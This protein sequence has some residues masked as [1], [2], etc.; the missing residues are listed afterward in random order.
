MEVKNTE[1]KDA[2][3]YEAEEVT[4]VFAMM[5]RTH[6]GRGLKKNGHTAEPETFKITNKQPK[7]AL[8]RD[9]LLVMDMVVDEDD[10]KKRVMKKTQRRT[11]QRRTKTRRT[12]QKR[13]KQRRTRQRRQQ[14]RLCRQ[15]GHTGRNTQRR[16]SVQLNL[17]HPSKEQPKKTVEGDSLLVKDMVVVDKDEKKKIHVKDTEDKTEEDKTEEDNREEDNRE[18][19]TVEV[20][21]TVKSHGG[22]RIFEKKNS[23]TTETKTS[24]KSNKQLKKIVGQDALLVKDVVVNEKD[25]K[26]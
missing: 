19:V 9:S 22:G 24:K 23:H 8:G 12:M 20:A 25:K 6:G 13:M 21:K 14:W 7:K 26:R 2:E 3:V 17:R 10:E 18:E 11:T 1:E 5:V 16:T 15:Q 4:L